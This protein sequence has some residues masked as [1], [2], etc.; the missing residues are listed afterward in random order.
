MQREEALKRSTVI[1][2]VAINLGQRSGRRLYNTCILREAASGLYDRLAARPMVSW[3]VCSHEGR[4]LA[5]PF[6][7]GWSAGW[8]KFMAFGQFPLN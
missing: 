5:L 8:N 3:H 1:N 2:F 6:A 4:A 7:A